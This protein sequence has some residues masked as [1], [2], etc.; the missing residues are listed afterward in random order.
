MKVCIMFFFK[1][2][3]ERLEIDQEIAKVTLLFK[4]GKGVISISKINCQF[5]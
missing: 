3:L 2:E 5:L 1:R 4:D